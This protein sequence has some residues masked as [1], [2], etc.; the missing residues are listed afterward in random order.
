[1]VIVYV[2]SCTYMAG[3]ANENMHSWITASARLAF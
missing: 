1:M 2:Y 3:V